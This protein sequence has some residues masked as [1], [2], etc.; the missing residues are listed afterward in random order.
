MLPRGGLAVWTGHPSGSSTPFLLA[1]SVSLTDFVQ[2]DTDSQNVGLQSRL[3]WIRKAGQE[4]Y[5][6]FNHQWQ[7]D[8]LDRF[9]TLSSD[10]RA[11][12][13]YTIRF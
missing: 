4:M 3:R 12:V 1:R 6:V 10:L 7:E 5:V 9:A 11:K 2:Y 13:N 8:A